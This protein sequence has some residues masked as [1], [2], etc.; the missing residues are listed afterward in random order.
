MFH[1]MV[2]EVNRSLGLASNQK[3]V[4][5]VAGSDLRQRLLL[6]GLGSLLL[7][8]IFDR[9]HRVSNMLICRHGT[10]MSTPLHPESS[11]H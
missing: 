10:D 8:W 7:F 9:R 11:S 5:H 4:Q 1:R 3:S 6:H 2:A